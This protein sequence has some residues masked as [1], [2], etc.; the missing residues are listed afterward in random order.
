[1]EA[2]ILDEES[3]IE[4]YL[5][6]G[7]RE[8]RIYYDSKPQLENIVIKNDNHFNNSIYNDESINKLFDKIYVITL[9]D[10]DK[11]NLITNYLKQFKIN[12]KF[13]YGINGKDKKYIEY[14]NDYL[15][16]PTSDPR[17]H[18]LDSHFD[19]SKRLIRGPGA[20]GLALTYK[21]IFKEAINKK[22]KYILI[23][24]EDCLLDKNINLHVNNFFTYKK[25]FDL[26]FLGA[27]H[28]SWNNPEIL[29]IE[30]TITNYYLAPAV[31]DGTFGIAYNCKVLP[32]LLD[33]LKI[34]K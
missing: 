27:S 7:K 34:I 16:W 10:K 9:K 31:L 28:H 26:L 5:L 20:I 2:G 13:Y 4:H 8:G 14:Y 1:M 30:N 6:F 11:E 33:N 17:R 19:Q 21:K 3:A 29:N 18:I 22:Y 12:F 24:E 23:L 32:Q 25:D 15:S